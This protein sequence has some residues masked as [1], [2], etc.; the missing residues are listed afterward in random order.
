MPYND[1][2]F[3]RVLECAELYLKKEHTIRSVAKQLGVG[4]S[5]VHKDLVERLPRINTYIAKRT[6]Q[7]LVINKRQG[8]YRGGRS[9]KEKYFTKGGA[10]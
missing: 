2:I 9:T 4:R 5:T 7:K 6:A 3:Y 8:P 1:V 10:G